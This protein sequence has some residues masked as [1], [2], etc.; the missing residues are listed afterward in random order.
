M[1]LVQQHLYNPS[2]SSNF[3][4]VY[5]RSRV[6]K[7][8]LINSEQKKLFKVKIDNTNKKYYITGITLLLLQQ[9]SLLCGAHIGTF[10]LVGLTIL[11]LETIE[12]IHQPKYQLIAGFISLILR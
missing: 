5:F 3:V 9:N 2:K 11:K 1:I 8:S 7:R 12:M 10:Y 4:I 6:D